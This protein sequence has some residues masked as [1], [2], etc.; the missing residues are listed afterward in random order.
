MAKTRITYLAMLLIFAAGLWGI[1]R[2]G[3][4][5]HGPPDVAGEWQIRWTSPPAG[6]DMPDRLSISQSGQFLSVTLDTRARKQ[7]AVQLQGTLTTKSDR[8]PQ[9]ALGNSPQQWSM[10][11]ELDAV[12]QTFSGHLDSPIR[13]DW[14]ARKTPPAR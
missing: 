11:G 7:P 10:S 14:Q 9:I 6:A 3:S 5:L 2:I 8:A 4:H 1:L 13:C 12:R